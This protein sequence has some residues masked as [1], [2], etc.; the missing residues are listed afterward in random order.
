MVFYLDIKCNLLKC[1]QYHCVYVCLCV[2]NFATDGMFVRWK[3]DH[4]PHHNSK[5]TLPPSASSSTI[6]KGSEGYGT[7][8]ISDDPAQ[9]PN[10]VP[11]AE[12]FSFLSEMVLFRLLTYSIEF[13]KNLDKI[14]QRFTKEH[15]YRKMKNGEKV[16][17]S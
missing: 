14:P 1:L 9:W 16:Q 3:K 10:K 4:L 13:P 5:D 11:D 15:Y 7:W 2:F 6:T 8:M 12:C 17:W